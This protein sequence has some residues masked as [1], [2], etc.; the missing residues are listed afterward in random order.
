MHRRRAERAAALS[1]CL[2]AVLCDLPG[3]WGKEGKNRP[4]FYDGGA[5]HDLDEDPRPGEPLPYP[6]DSD[7]WQRPDTTVHVQISSFR[8]HRCP[9]TL[10]NL[11]TKAKFP[12]RVR[13]GVVQQNEKDDVGGARP[14]TPRLKP[15]T[16]AAGAQTI[17]QNC[18]HADQVKMMRVPASGAKGPT[19]GR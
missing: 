6:P 4:M 16:A 13:V 10:Y 18:P 3:A 9:K 17:L 12:G 15:P 11:F 1:L 19:Y 14:F 7:S 2:L 5:W 8:D